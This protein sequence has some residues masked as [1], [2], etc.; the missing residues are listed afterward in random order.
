M[1]LE[2]MS[3]NH[4]ENIQQAEISTPVAIEVSLS[5]LSERE[6]AIVEGVVVADEVLEDAYCLEGVVVMES[7]EESIEG[8]PTPKSD[9]ATNTLPT[10]IESVD[11]KL[12]KQSTEKYIT[13][14]S[15]WYNL[16][17]VENISHMAY[18]EFYND[19]DQDADL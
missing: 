14:L 13:K 19:F 3:M 10:L 18:T 11:A 7:I 16:G 1:S 6:V 17:H 9:M 15:E 4:S 12:K 5:N 2:I 8:T